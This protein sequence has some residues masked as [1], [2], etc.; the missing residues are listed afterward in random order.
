MPEPLAEGF[1]EISG[2]WSFKT[3]KGDPLPQADFLIIR[4]EL[5]AVVGFRHDN[6]GYFVVARQA[7][8]FRYFITVIRRD[9]QIPFTLDNKNRLLDVFE[10]G[11]RRHLQFLAE[12]GQG[13]AEDLLV[14]PEAFIDALTAPGGLDDLRQV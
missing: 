4:R 13:E 6:K 2:V 8:R 11:C 9:V 3:F 12:T 5:H 14:R 1:K 7:Q 10:Q